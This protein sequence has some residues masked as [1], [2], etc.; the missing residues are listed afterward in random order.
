MKYERPTVIATYKVDEL[1]KEAAVC[2]VYCV[3]EA[4]A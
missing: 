3:K 1:M 2:T 4:E